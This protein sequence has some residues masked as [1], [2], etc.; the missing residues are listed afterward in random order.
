[1]HTFSA[2]AHHAPSCSPK[3]PP[4]AHLFLVARRHCLMKRMSFGTSSWQMFHCQN[5]PNSNHTNC[6]SNTHNSGGSNK[7][8]SSNHNTPL[9]NKGCG[10][11]NH[12]PHSTTTTTATTATTVATTTTFMGTHQHCRR[13]LH[14]HRR[15]LLRLRNSTTQVPT[16]ATTH[17]T[18]TTTTVNILYFLMNKCKEQ[19]KI[20]CEHWR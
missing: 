2:H 8:S 3:S 13:Q 20:D 5:T 16:T 6:S 12:N 15:S 17:T 9:F 18:T 4:H 14:Q 1:M 19:N 10:Y 7:D 11:N